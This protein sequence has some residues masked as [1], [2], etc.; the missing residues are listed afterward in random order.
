MP[1]IAD[2]TGALAAAGVSPSVRLEGLTAAGEWECVYRGSEQKLLLRGLPP[3]ILGLSRVRVSLDLRKCV[4][5]GA[6]SITI[7]DEPVHSSGGNGP[8][9]PNGSVE[10]Y[11]FAPSDLAGPSVAESMLDDSGAE[12][13]AG[14]SAG[15]SAG[16]K[17]GRPFFWDMSA[18]TQVLTAPTPLVFDGNA[19]Y[20]VAGPKKPPRPTLEVSWEEPRSIVPGVSIPRT[21]YALEVFDASLDRWARVYTG[22]DNTVD[23]CALSEARKLPESLRPEPAVCLLT[24]VARELQGHSCVYSDEVVTFLSPMAPVAQWT[25]ESQSSVLLSWSAALDLSRL[26]HGA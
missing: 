20:L 4:R 25:D 22:S 14:A 6:G 5:E 7:S 17:S 21:R 19:E 8:N 18:Y 23:L 26:P 13:G 11:P 15:A 16:G 9:G 1:S 2:P 10:D 12:G 3:N 24:R